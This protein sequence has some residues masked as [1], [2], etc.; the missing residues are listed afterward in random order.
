MLAHLQLH[1]AHGWRLLDAAEYD[2]PSATANAW[3]IELV[4]LH[5]AHRIH[6]LY[7]A[8]D[9]A[10]PRPA[11]LD[12]RR[13]AESWMSE[14][15]LGDGV[16]G[17]CDFRINAAAVA[18]M[19]A[20]TGEVIAAAPAPTVTF[21]YEP[22]STATVP[23]DRVSRARAERIAREVRDVLRPTCA[24]IEIAGSIRRGVAT[25]KDAEIVAIATPDTLRLM[26]GLVA[27]ETWSK[28]L[29][30]DGPRKT[31]RWG[32]KYRGIMADGLRIEIFMTE[33]E[34]WGLMYWM[35]TGPASANQA[36]MG[37]LGRSSIRVQDGA[38]WHAT[39]WE[40]DGSGKRWIAAEPVR[41]AVHS[42][43]DW[44]ALLGLDFVAPAQREAA[45]YD[46]VRVDTRVIE[47]L[48]VAPAVTPV[49]PVQMGLFGGLS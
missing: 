49:T 25:V 36:L 44:F 39:K 29:Y 22:A 41:V 18:L 19:L 46:W 11:A 38:V 3:R 32:P 35:R 20:D 4:N 31:H 27:A 34:S 48:K 17:A 14:N 16:P 2:T 24:Q 6:V 21:R 47:R 40:R 28:A 23:S 13:R 1:H 12:L 42:E 7:I 30:G 8:P 43:V 10:S 45:I 9:G 15:E 5:N 26:D 37:R 33:A